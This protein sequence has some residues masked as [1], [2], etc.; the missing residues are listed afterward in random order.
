MQTRLMTQ[1]RSS[2]V[3]VAC[4]IALFC[5]ACSDPADS[6]VLTADPPL[7]LEDHLDVATIEGSEVP[8][9]LPEPVEWRFDEPQPDWKATP[10]WNA[11]PPA[12][13]TGTADGLLVTL[14]DA[15]RNRDGNPQGGIYIEVPDFEQ[16]DWEYVVVR[17][18]SENEVSRIGVHFNLREG[19][20]ASTDQPYPYEDGEGAPV[21]RDGTVQTYQFQTDL[22]AWKQLGL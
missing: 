4:L 16:A 9:D 8:A 18:R 14:T 10:P 1:R 12:R 5:T 3:A 13:L 15:M 11:N 21:I 19:S 6:V 2:F 17:A 22:I 20:G 7:H